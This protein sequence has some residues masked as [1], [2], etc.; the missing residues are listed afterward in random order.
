MLRVCPNFVPCSTPCRT[1]DSTTS[2]LIRGLQAADKGEILSRDGRN[3]ASV[4]ARMEKAAP[5]LKL[6]VEEYLALVVP[7][8]A[9]FAHKNVG[10][11]ETVEFR[12]KVE[13]ATEPWRFP[14]I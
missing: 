10:H 6:R 8:L 11:M 2:M 9:G 7:G 14:A 13:G 12:Q 3:L 5:S 4:A 1:W